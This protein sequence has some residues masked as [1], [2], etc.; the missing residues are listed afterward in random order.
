MLILSR[1]AN[2]SIRIGRDRLVTV[3][4]VRRDTVQLVFS[5]RVRGP[6]RRIVRDWIT[7]QRDGEHAFGADVTVTAVDIRGEK[8]RLGFTV[9]ANLMVHRREVYDEIC[10]GDEWPDDRPDDDRR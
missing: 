2:D 5:E 4:S 6:I 9:P 10:P 8:V 1:H 7:L 3:Q